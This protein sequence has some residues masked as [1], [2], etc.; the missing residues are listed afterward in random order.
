[1]T[2]FCPRCGMPNED[3]ARFCVRCGYNFYEQPVGG[4]NLNQ[5]QTMNML[6][7][8]PMGGNALL[9]DLDTLRSAFFWLFLG[10]ILLIIPLV[11]IVAFIFVLVGFILL[12]IGYGKISKSSLR[13]TAIYRSVRNWLII[14]FVYE[15]ISVVFSVV[16][17]ILTFTISTTYYSTTP[18][19]STTSSIWPG[20]LGIL[21]ILLAV[22]SLIIYLISY[23]KLISS[24]K[25]LS[26]DLGV[27]RLRN[28]GNYL[29]YA[30]ILGIVAFV[31]TVIV[32]AINGVIA[33]ITTSASSP[34]IIYSLL[35]ALVI[36]LVIGLVSYIL[37]II[38]YYNAYKGI[39][40][41]KS[42]YYYQGPGMP[43]NYP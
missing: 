9:A 31:V 30:L 43:V 1:M 7:G 35:F 27:Q 6:P 26:E 15:L 13:N 42:R 21:I 36:P 40:E 24:L 32:I 39:D 16:I 3:N 4:E 14:Y 8:Q 18:T 34:G 5:Q 25:A 12:I 10:T 11:D 33:S 22:I 23:L 17:I 2:K 19:T 37:Q 29:F 20:F 28:A 38:A 41:F